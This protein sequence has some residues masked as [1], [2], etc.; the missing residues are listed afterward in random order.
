MVQRAPKPASKVTFGPRKV[1]APGTPKPPASTLD[2]LVEDYLMACRAKGLSP[3][4]VDNSYGYPLRGIF[5]PWCH[6]QR[7]KGLDAFGRPRRRRVLG[8]S[9]GNAWPKR[10]PAFT[11]QRACLHPVGAR[12]PQLVRARG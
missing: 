6:D 9:H 5:L 4:T 12:L 11:R 1:P 8:L 3:N 2:Q 10:A 7:I